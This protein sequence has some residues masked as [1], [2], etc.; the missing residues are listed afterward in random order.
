[1]Q[2]VK[3][4]VGKSKLVKWLI[5]EE[6]VIPLIDSWWKAFEETKHEIVMTFNEQAK[7]DIFN[8]VNSHLKHI[9]PNLN[10]SLIGANASYN[11][12]LSITPGLRLDLTPLAQL[13]IRRAPVCPGWKFSWYKLRDDFN[14]VC[15][16]AK[17]NDNID[18]NTFS[19]F[20]GID[21]FNQINLVFV[22][23]EIDS[24][25]SYADAILQIYNAMGSLIGGLNFY[26]W[27]G[28][29]D[30]VTQVPS[31]EKAYHI[32][33]LPIL[34]EKYILI[35]QNNMP[36]KPFFIHK[37][38]KQ[39]GEI[40]FEP[41]NPCNFSGR[42]DILLACTMLPDAMECAHNKWKFYSQQFSRF[43]EFFCY[44]KIEITDEPDLAGEKYKEDL[45][46][47]LNATL[48]E[49]RIGV[50]T[51]AG[52]GLRHGYIDFVLNSISKGGRI[53]Q[54]IGK[55]FKLPKN[56]WILFFD[57]VM[58]ANWIGIYEDTPIPPMPDFENRPIRIFSEALEDF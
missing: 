42:S 5:D 41:A 43:R 28:S 27:I 24:K 46:N 4:T 40:E 48:V 32:S 15:A 14:L 37:N 51:G 26:L 34:L 3:S 39:W 44:L 7:L 2:T 31:D 25:E 50:V 45:L 10:F 35:A 36:E 8:F 47:A 23:K 12:R 53:I 21:K 20:G 33:K 56:S 17:Y 6:Q 18:L 16:L 13:I 54:K 49:K 9:N 58:E 55:K 11:N 30:I 57:S 38:G 52:T 22:C 1:M 29:I 19:F